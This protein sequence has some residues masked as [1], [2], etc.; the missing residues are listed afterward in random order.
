VWEGEVTALQKYFIKIKQQ[1]YL[2]GFN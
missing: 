2:N 1:L